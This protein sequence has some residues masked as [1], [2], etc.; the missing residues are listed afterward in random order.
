MPLL[1]GSARLTFDCDTY[2]K[3]KVLKLLA[4]RYAGTP[5]A[6]SRLSSSFNHDGYY[7]TTVSG[8]FEVP[9]S[10]L[11]P[12][13]RAQLLT[14]Y[15]HWKAIDAMFLAEP[16]EIAECSE[17]FEWVLP[18]PIEPFVQAHPLN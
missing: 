5:L 18:I 16:G 2:G 4:R 6:Y 9:D 15:I 8:V 1:K 13:S 10:I 14:E 7:Y 11:H 12:D 17:R 3:E